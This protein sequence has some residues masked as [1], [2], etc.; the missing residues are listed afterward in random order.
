MS[1]T[2]TSKWNFDLLSLG[3][4]TFRLFHGI[5]IEY[6]MR[7]VIQMIKFS[8]NRTKRNWN[9]IFCY[10]HKK[11]GLNDCCHIFCVDRD[12]GRERKKPPFSVSEHRVY[13][14]SIWCAVRTEKH[15]FEMT[16]KE[17]RIWKFSLWKCA[18]QF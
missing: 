3:S 11:N 8:I 14:T 12:E 7:T 1:I 16:T 13:L 17:Y 5:L 9:W 6:Q 18:C 2:M 10:L 15:F 4:W